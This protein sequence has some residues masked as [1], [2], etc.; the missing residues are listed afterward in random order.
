MMNMHPRELVDVLGRKSG[1]GCDGKTYTDMIRG[2]HWIEKSKTRLGT[3]L[4]RLSHP[5]NG[6]PNDMPD[7]FEVFAARVISY[8]WQF[9]TQGGMRAWD[10][11]QGIFK[12]MILDLKKSGHDIPGR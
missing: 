6:S 9:D 7:I 4:R 12:D 2:A 3:I 5:R 8:Y 1:P 11:T 10:Q